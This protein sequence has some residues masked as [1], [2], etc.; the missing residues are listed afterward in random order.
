M[1][2]RALRRLPV[3]RARWHAAVRS[4]QRAQT[5]NQRAARRDRMRSA[6]ARDP[7]KTRQVRARC[8]PNER[9]KG[10]RRAAIV[11]DRRARAPRSRQAEARGR[12][13]QGPAR[14]AAR[15]TRRSK[16]RRTMPGAGYTC[17]LPNGPR[18]AAAP[19]H[20]DA[21]TQRLIVAS[22]LR[23]GR[24]TTRRSSARRAAPRETRAAGRH[25]W[26]RTAPRAASSR[27]ASRRS[28]SS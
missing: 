5:S 10:R 14:A 12:A 22:R 23:G 17:S 8:S 24:R 9:R 15:R 1:M 21:T 11:Q 4:H 18:M 7:S 3:G 6:A 13:G 27:C 19:L 2:E 25:R 16:P 28:T 20:D 26:H